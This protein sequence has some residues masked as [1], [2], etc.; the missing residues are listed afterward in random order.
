MITLAVLLSI[1]IVIAVAVV[2]FWKLVSTLNSSISKLRAWKSR[3]V[4][5][6]TGKGLAGQI[7]S[8]A[9]G[10]VLDGLIVILLGIILVFTFV[11]IIEDN[12]STANITNPTTKTFGD[13]A[14]WLLPVLAIIGLVYLGIRLF[15]KRGANKG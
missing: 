14:G 8:I 1:F 11:P 6:S 13:L 4:V 3:L 10:G 5:W 15:I 9:V 2:N 7:G 12:S